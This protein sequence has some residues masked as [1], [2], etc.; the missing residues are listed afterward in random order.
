MNEFRSITCCIDTRK[1]PDSFVG[2]E[3][4]RR[5]LNE[6]PPEVDPCGENGEFHS[7]AFAGPLFAHEIPVRTR[8]KRS[9]GIPF[10]FAICY[11]SEMTTNSRSGLSKMTKSRFLLLAM[12]I[13]AAV[14]VR[15]I[16]YVLGAMGLT[17]VHQFTG[18]LWNF[19]PIM[20]LFLF[21]GARFP[22]VAGRRGPWRP[23]CSAMWQSVCFWET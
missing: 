2:R 19:S 15:L 13:A 10:C 8:R 12:I 17:D 20:A 3:I 18:F 5:F 4:D 11:Q 16:P 14:S 9:A 1:L 23:C 22:D 21:T 6:L 7:F